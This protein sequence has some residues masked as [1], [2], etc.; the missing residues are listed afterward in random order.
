MK[1]LILLL[2]AV[3]LPIG[4][5]AL[6]VSETFDVGDSVSVALY[7][8]YET[9]NPNGIGF[10]VLKSSAAGE[11]TVTLIYDGVVGGSATVYDQANPDDNHDATAVLEQ[12]VV[13]TK[14]NQIINKEGAKWNIE[15][16]SLLSASDVTYLGLSK[17][18]AGIFEIPAKYSFLA[19][20]KATGVPAS[21]YNYW[22]QIPDA[23]ASNTSVF[24]VI[25]N[26]ARTDANG[27]WATLE[28]QDITGITNNVEF[29]IRPV[30]VIK[31]EYIICNNSKTP[32]DPT[33]VVYYCKAVDGKYY[34][35]D[36]KEVTE[37]E[38]KEACEQK[39]I[40]KVEDGKYYDRK[41][42]VVT[43]AEYEESCEAAPTCKIVNGKYFDK[44]GKVV[45]KAEYEES[46]A[47]SPKTGVEDYILPLGAVVMLAGAA[48]IIIRKKTMFK[49]F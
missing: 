41:G 42:N 12:S 13:G 44:N 9:E 25:Y 10:H 43:K 47:S 14:L 34:D 1:K 39:P 3:I 31:K 22:T 2:I 17:N 18:A 24:A 38:Y 32:E 48:A 15:S 23:S 37:T 40:C 21:M 49:E 20:I 29:G 33:P 11:A 7:D 45:T 4:V 8:G 27:V 26:E 5:H 36:G 19:P 28:S 30:V 6:A 16:A 46:C 35:A